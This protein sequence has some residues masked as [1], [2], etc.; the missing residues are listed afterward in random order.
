MI[1]I[2]IKMNRLVSICA[3]SPLTAAR[4]E[5][6]A[7]SSE[8]VKDESVKGNDDLICYP[9]EGLSQLNLSRE[10]L[11]VAPSAT[12]LMNLIGRDSMWRSTTAC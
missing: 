9:R 12:R 11:R 5:D 2:K 3:K 7:Q 8:S 4:L 10:V 6:A 1:N